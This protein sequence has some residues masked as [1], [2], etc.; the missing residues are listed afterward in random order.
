MRPLMLIFLLSRSLLLWGQDDNPP[1]WYV[2]ILNLPAREEIPA[3]SEP[4]I[5][6]V[7][8]DGFRLT[9]SMIAP[10]LY[11]SPGEIPDNQQDDDGNGFVDDHGGWDVADVDADVLPAPERIGNYYHGT[12]VAGA[13][14]D[15]LTRCYGP[16]ASRYYRILPIKA[17]SDFAAR[18]YVR[19]GY[20]AINYAVK[21]GADLIV[22]AWNGGSESEEMRALL[23]E[24]RRLGI[25]VVAS[26]GNTYSERA[27]PPAS[28]PEVIAVAAVDEQLRKLEVSNY[29]MFVDLAG[30]GRHVQGADVLR[31]D[32]ARTG[33]GTSAA[34]SVVAACLAILNQVAPHRTVEERLDA[35]KNAARPVEAINPSYAG[36]LGSGF[37]DVAKAVGHLNALETC[38]AT[39]NP[40]LPEGSLHAGFIPSK[41]REFEWRLEP[42]GQYKGIWLELR[43]PAPEKT[44]AVLKVF[45]KKEALVGEIPLS[46]HSRKLFVPGNVAKVRYIQPKAKRAPSFA[47]DYYVETIDSSTLYCREKRY[48]ELNKGTISD[49]SRASP[50]ANNSDCKWQIRVGEGQRVRLRF[51]DFDTQAATDFLYLFDGESTLPENIIAR[52]SGPDIPPVVTSRTNRVLVW[53]VT[54]SRV[55]GE[56]WTLEYE[57]VDGN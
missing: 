30:P 4:V 26:A 46:G 21:Q 38:C 34:V 54:D 10:F 40:S 33:E 47:L 35:L 9:H 43:K 42:S 57:A 45:S 48:Y 52:F 11:N 19:Y 8:D 13:I 41:T 17:V 2:D 1:P 16:E 7:V 20:E 49:G 50:Y 37:P 53:F 14:T 28:F 24:A 5:I 18:P 25:A 51:S 22:C 6:A 31:D 3:S 39:H 29:G 27:M 44:Q 36:K 15:I 12:F 55:T 56:G 23:R 32:G